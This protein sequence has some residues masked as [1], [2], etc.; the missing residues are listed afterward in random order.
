MLLATYLSDLQLMLNDPN[1]QFYS[2]AALTNYI[3]RAR[4]YVAGRSQCCRFLTPS[5]GPIST[6]VTI[7]SG[8]SGY[9]TAPTVTVSRPD[10]MGGQ[11]FVPA[12]ATATI[13]AG[14]VTGVTITNPG[15][16]Y[17]NPPQ[18]SFTGGGGSGAAATGANTTGFL[19]TVNGREV[20]PFADVNALLTSAYPGVE[21]ILGV[22]SVSVAIGAMKPTLDWCD[23]LSFQAYARAANIGRG[24]PA[25][26]SQYAQ[27][28]TGSIYLSPVPSQKYQ[29]EWDCFVT[30]LDLSA[31]QLVDV[32][33]DPFAEPVKYYAAR[34]AYLNAQRKDDANFM[35]AECDRLLLEARGFVSPGRI[36]TMYPE[37]Y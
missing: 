32:I 15:T 33:P 37:M 12:T 28:Q 7:T 30:P 23:F 31:L 35:Q 29:M 22:A 14:Q 27:G 36:P 6:V 26:W 1:G 34:L 2:T 9:T 21:A 19:T 3:N 16:G 17:V 5:S 10:A 25:V 18:F 13:G 4:K 11:A 24:Q 20:Y 8:G